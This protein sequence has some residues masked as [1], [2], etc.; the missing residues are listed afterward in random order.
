L[1]VSTFPPTQ[2]QA[3]GFRLKRLRLLAGLTRQDLLIKYNIK[4]NTLKSWE[5]GCYKGI[6][7]ES[8]KKMLAIYQQEGVVCSLA[9]L[10]EGTGMLPNMVATFSLLEQ[11][12]A[13][14]SSRDFYPQIAL[15]EKQILTELMTFRKQHDN[16]VDCIVND[17]AMEPCFFT[18]DRVAGVACSEVAMD[19]LIG[20]ICIVGLQDGSL[21]VRRLMIGTKP[22]HYSLQ[23][24]NQNMTIAHTSLKNSK[25]QFAAEVIWVRRKNKVCH[26]QT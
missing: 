23:A 25:L 13:S 5:V 10:M 4:P 14:D 20:K 11:T 18:G 12:Q 21:L 2:A 9:W 3:R 15:E 17:N 24:L 1:K 16:S 26:T 6:P 22:H 7:Q 19:S 8:A